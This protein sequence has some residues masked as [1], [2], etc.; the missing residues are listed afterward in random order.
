MKKYQMVEINQSESIKNLFVKLSRTKNRIT[1]WQNVDN[2]H[3]HWRIVEF[4]KIDLRKNE[5]IFVPKKGMLDFDV[6]HP[7][8][9]YS[10][11]RTTI[12]KDHIFY[13]SQLSLAIKLPE[14]IMMENKRDKERIADTS[15]SYVKLFYGDKVFGNRDA[16]FK[17]PLLDRSEGG[18]SFKSSLNNVLKFQQGHELDFQFVGMEHFARGV[19]K[20]VTTHVSDDLKEKYYRIGV[21]VLQD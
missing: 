2:I 11:K 3:R 5:M 12:F 9:F 16:W 14:K 1:L 7:I 6:R 15:G 20:Y 17:S 18:F 21:K 10:L 19:I 13:N 8:Y 4:K